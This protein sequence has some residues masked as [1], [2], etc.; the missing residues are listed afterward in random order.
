MQPTGKV[1]ISSGKLSETCENAQASG[2]VVRG[3]GKENTQGMQCQKKKQKVQKKS[4]M[5]EEWKTL[6]LS[7]FHH[8]RISSYV[9]LANFHNIQK[10]VEFDCPGER[11][12]EQDCC[13]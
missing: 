10:S 3:G 6:L 1:S 13:C 9:P 7:P 11:S 2:E 8:T 4:L 12:P 5:R